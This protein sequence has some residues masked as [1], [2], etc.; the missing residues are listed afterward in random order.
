MN[1]FYLAQN[2]SPNPA[3]IKVKMSKVSRSLEG[4]SSLRRDR[5]ASRMDSSPRQVILRERENLNIKNIQEEK[6]S[7]Q[8][9][10]FEFKTVDS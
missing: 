6:K 1:S 8:K 4:I 9:A 10:E 7:S 3:E 5:G 2:I